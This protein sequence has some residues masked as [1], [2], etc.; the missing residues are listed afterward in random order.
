MQLSQSEAT[1]HKDVFGML[2]RAATPLIE[3]SL[4]YSVN[5]T[6][7]SKEFR[8]R[9][10]SSKDRQIKNISFINFHREQKKKLR[11]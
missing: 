6:N 10:S 3:N 5:S 9:V 11:I 1:I 2:V 4:P 8:N 7:A